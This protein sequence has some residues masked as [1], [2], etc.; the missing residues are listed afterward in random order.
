MHEAY[1]PP[2]SRKSE[3]R[4]AA[5]SAPAASRTTHD[6]KRAK[7]TTPKPPAKTSRKKKV[8]EAAEVGLLRRELAETRAELDAA[9]REITEVVTACREAESRVSAARADADA[10]RRLVAEVDSSA[11]AVR[12]IAEAA[13]AEVGRAWEQSEQTE[14]RVGRLRAWL[15]ETR[16]NFA[17]L[18]TEARQTLDD[19]RAAAA[20]L[21]AQ[22]A[23]SGAGST[24]A[25]EAEP[26]AASGP[27]LPDVPALPKEELADDVR[28]RLTHLLN[29]AWGVEK[30]Q[31]GLLQTFADES[32]DRDIRVLL[33]EH[34][35]AA[36]RR[37]EAVQARLESLGTRPA[38]ERGLLGQ[39]V[40]RIWE[41]MR[42]PR[43]QADRAVLSLLKAVSAA[44]FQAALYAALH[45]CARSAGDEETAELAAGNFRE[46]SGEADRLRAALP[47]TVGRIVRR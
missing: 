25:A 31:V 40:T 24:A 4:P 5:G 23:E 46:Q 17:T 29:D 6:R 13:Q 26:D 39:L 35:A 38:S 1:T 8:T 11:A 21:R 12:G 20:A 27:E 34:R 36:Q 22:P 14:Q 18:S 41:A 16:G 37:Q 32:G 3:P 15:E 9:R 19:I 28:E 44:E 45:A 42:A 7:S 30:E 2:N 43:D 33:E 10:V 47:T